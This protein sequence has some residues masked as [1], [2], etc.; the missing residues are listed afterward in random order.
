ML[1]GRKLALARE[2]QLCPIPRVRRDESP[3]RQAAER[4][5][6]EWR[7]QQKTMKGEENPRPR[8][9][10]QAWGT[11]RVCLFP[12]GIR[13]GLPLLVSRDEAAKLI[14]AMP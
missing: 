10:T 3:D 9:K 6:G 12:D 2:R 11:L 7:S 5:S 1:H 8:L 14:D 4:H 13:K